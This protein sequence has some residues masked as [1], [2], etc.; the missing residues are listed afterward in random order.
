MFNLLPSNKS[1]VAE[2]QAALE[3]R[4]TIKSLS[5]FIDKEDILRV[6]GRLKHSLLSYEEQYRI[7]LPTESHL[8]ELAAQAYYKRALYGGTQLTLSL[9]RQKYWIPRGRLLMK[10]CI[11]QCTSV[12]AMAGGISP[13]SD[14]R[15]AF[16]S[17]HSWP[18]ISTRRT[19]LRR[20]DLFTNCARARI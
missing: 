11:Y 2:K 3:N 9:L 8:P 10:K 20:S 1:S 5:P 12:R 16:R 18:S 17:R 7:I 14:E 15:L 19:R 4:S 13:A 6:G